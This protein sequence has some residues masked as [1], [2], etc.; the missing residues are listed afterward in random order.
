MVAKKIDESVAGGDIKRVLRHRNSKAYFKDGGWTQNAAEADSFSD[1]M[2][3][4]ETCVR[5]GLCDVELALRYEAATTDI[6]CTP[7]R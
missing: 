4:A 6:F 7:I 2:E 1:V 5:Y 3:V